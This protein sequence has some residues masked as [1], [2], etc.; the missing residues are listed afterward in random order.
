MLNEKLGYYICDNIKFQSKIQALFYSKKVN[1]PVY[2]W[3]NDLEFSRNKWSVEPPHSLDYYYDQRSKQLREQYDYLI[4]SYSGGSDSHNI[5]TSFIRQNLHIDE[6]IVFHFNKGNEK[7]KEVLKDTFSASR[8]NSE[9]DIQ[10]IPRLKELANKLEKTKITVID[11]TDHVFELFEEAGDESWVL[12][13]IE[14]LNPIGVSR[15]NYIYLDKVRKQFDKNKTIGL[16]LGIDKPKSLIKQGKFYL[17]FNDRTANQGSIINNYKDYSNTSI[18]Y[19]YW[20]PSCLDM[21]TKQGHVIKN[22][23]QLNPQFIKFWDVSLTT[24]RLTKLT[25]EIFLRDILYTTWNKNWYQ[26]SKPTLDWVSENDTWFIE[27]EANSRAFEIWKR[28]V[29]FVKNNLSSYSVYN[30]EIDTIDGLVPFVKEFCIGNV[31][32]GITY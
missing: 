16:I 24:P 10:C 22:W 4:L 15:Y 1:K 25:H 28:G 2:W 12:N 6:I 9:V 20:D 17:R 7:H 18:E 13:K 11:L 30:D 31:D 14:G 3:F 8:L 29:E 5:L 23:L 32:T 27:G 19:F 21:I 26:V